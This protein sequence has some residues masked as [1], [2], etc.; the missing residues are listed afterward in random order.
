[1]IEKEQCRMGEENPTRYG[2]VWNYGPESS[3]V[4]SLSSFKWKDFVC[5]GERGKVVEIYGEVKRTTMV[6]SQSPRWST[7][8]CKYILTSKTV[9]FSWNLC[10]FSANYT[11]TEQCPSFKVASNDG[12]IQSSVG[13]RKLWTTFHGS[14][15]SRNCHRNNLHGQP[16]MPSLILIQ[17]RYVPSFQSDSP[18]IAC[19]SCSFPLGTADAEIKGPTGGSLGLSKVPS[20]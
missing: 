5:F 15:P 4:F 19:F 7:R 17:F 6:W 11:H 3:W 13:E 10:P 12:E 16:V 18:S 9:Y 20:F 14:M 1:M 8:N 2:R